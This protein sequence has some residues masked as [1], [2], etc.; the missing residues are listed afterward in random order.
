MIHSGIVIIERGEPRKLVFTSI[1]Q[2]EDGGLQANL[3]LPPCTLDAP[4]LLPN[5]GT[6]LFVKPA[7]LSELCKLH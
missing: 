4:T 1:A 7:N 5:V 3:E 6:A 2:A